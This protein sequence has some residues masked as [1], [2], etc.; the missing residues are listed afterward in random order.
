L[1]AHQ[2]SNAEVVLSGAANAL[3]DLGD[4]DLTDTLGQ[5]NGIAVT[6]GDTLLVRFFR[7]NIGETASAVDDARLVKLSPSIALS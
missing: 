5:V 3:R 4:I 7:D 1:P 6:A 2:S